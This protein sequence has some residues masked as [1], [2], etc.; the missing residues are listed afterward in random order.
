[1]KII[2]YA[3]NNFQNLLCLEA[4]KAWMESS[5]RLPHQTVF[6][7][8]VSLKRNSKSVTATYLHGRDTI[9]DFTQ[10]EKEEEDINQLKLKL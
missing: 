5:E 4:V 9:M 10:P 1:M 3:S 8:L 2:L 6:N 7:G